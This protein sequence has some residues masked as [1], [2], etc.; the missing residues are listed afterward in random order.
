MVVA[1]VVISESNGAGETVTDN[2][3]NVNFGSVDAPNLSYA[4]NPVVAGTPS[5]EKWLRIKLV[6]PNDSNKID[7][8]QVYM[9]PAPSVAGVSYKTNLKTAPLNQNA[10]STPTNAVST[11]ATLTMPT[12]D[13]GAENIGVG[14]G[15]GGLSTANSYSDYIVLQIQTTSST[16]PG[17]VPQKTF[18]FEYDEQ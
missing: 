17:D 9:T 4:D 11:V 1:T 6:N 8:F 16:P 14:G 18:H 13:P 12:S 10:Y 15:S 3:S 7:N 2:I 5:F